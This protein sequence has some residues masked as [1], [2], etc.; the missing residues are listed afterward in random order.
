[1][2][3]QPG[4]FQR[5]VFQGAGSGVY[6]TISAQ[7]HGSD[8][9]A[10][11]IA[12][13]PK[14]WL[15]LDGMESGADIAS[16]LVRVRVRLAL[17]AQE[18]GADTAVV[19]AR[20]RIALALGALEAGQD[21]AAVSLETVPKPW[22]TL[23]GVETGKD[24][25]SILATSEGQIIVIARDIEGGLGH[26]IE[27]DCWDKQAGAPATLNFASIGFTTL[28][29]D[30][31][32]N[33]HYLERAKVPGDYSRSLFANGT[34]HGQIS[35][36]AGYIEIVGNDG[37]LDD[38]RSRYAFDG[39]ALRIKTIPRLRPRYADAV[40]IFSGTVEQLEMGWD[41]VTV[42]IRDR[43]AEL[44]VEHQDVLYAGTTI[45]GG[46]NEAEGTPDDLKGKGKELAYGAPLMV[47]AVAANPFDNIFGLGGDGFEAVE[48]VRDRGVALTA[49]GTDY[50]TI[51]TLRAASIAAGRYATAKALGLIR[52]GS[53]PSGQLTARPVEKANAT[54]RTA[55]QIARR[56]LMRKG[57]V[58]GQHFLASDIAALDALNPAPIGYWMPPEDQT[59]LLAVQRVLG[60]IGASI[61]PDRLGVYRM[62][63]FGAPSGYPVATLTPAE[64]LEGKINL[65]ATGDEGRG[66]PAWRVTVQYA[67]NWYP[68]D[69]DNLDVDTS[70]AFKAFATAE[71][72]SAVAEDPG[73]KAVHRLA[74]DLTFETYLTEEADA[75]AEANRQL[76]LH[77]VP[78]ERFQV[79]V[80]S[81]LV[82]RV[83][84][85]STV[86]LQLDR[87][88][89]GAGKDFVTIGLA[90]NFAS[91]NTTLDLWG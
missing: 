82:E 30:P 77:S 88:G 3:F 15:Q 52:T 20:P 71:W 29:S 67:R 27:L 53:K 18:A 81:F 90:E 11:D 13:V 19:V 56:M 58:E 75:L 33:V 48:D 50:A 23:A 73:V 12:T 91:G 80:K 59:T 68:M 55:A 34:T 16:A 43:L 38:L 41:K 45:S 7:E 85:A 47:P 61:V 69:R 28:P 87:F 65:L 84:L 78:R 22:L 25:A 74:S 79:Q 89:L 70:E 1:M 36:G 64:I 9:A 37:A 5:G 4:V 14:A 83:E 54:D 66:V 46:M 2:V 21:A 39:Y 57:F 44:D 26:L 42:R 31:V 51:A 6:V 76:L 24:S 72:R 40:T 62:M 10:I 63:R 86:R 8:S 49:T 32:P 35:V 60:S 17:A